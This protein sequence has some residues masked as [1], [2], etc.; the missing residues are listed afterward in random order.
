MMMAGVPENI[1]AYMGTYGNRRKVELRK[2][3]GLGWQC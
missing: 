3:R 2:L 1:R